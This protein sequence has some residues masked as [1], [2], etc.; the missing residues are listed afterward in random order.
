VSDIQGE[1]EQ[2]SPKQP[3]H[4]QWYILLLSRGSFI[5]NQNLGKHTLG[6]IFV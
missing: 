3:K 1:P 4:M 5:A 6:Y 2:N